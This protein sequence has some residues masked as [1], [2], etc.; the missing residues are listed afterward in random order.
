[1]PNKCVKGTNP[2]PIINSS[3]YTPINVYLSR[4]WTWVSVV[5][6]TNAAISRELAGHWRRD[7]QV[8][9]GRDSCQ[10]L[11]PLSGPCGTAISGRGGGHVQE[12]TPSSGYS[13]E[14][15]AGLYF[16]HS[17][18]ALCHGHG[19]AQPRCTHQ[20]RIGAAGSHLLPNMQG[21]AA[22]KMDAWL[23]GRRGAESP[24]F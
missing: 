3:H 1:M 5:T 22:D 6:R 23:A 2:I 9:V 19:V 24:K 21:D 20:G 11:G 18:I 16:A 10:T 7:D 14:F 4:R 12:S 13:A 17:R 15:R 8:V